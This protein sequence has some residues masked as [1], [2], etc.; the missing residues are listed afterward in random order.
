MVGPRRVGFGSVTAAGQILRRDVADDKLV[1]SATRDLERDFR[2]DYLDSVASR[3]AANVDYIGQLWALLAWY[4]DIRLVRARR[5]AGAGCV[6][7]LE[8]A[9]TTIQSAIDE[10][11]KQFDRFLVERGASAIDMAG[12]EALAHPWC[13]AEGTALDRPGGHISW[14]QSLSAAEIEISGRWLGQIAAT[15]RAAAG[16]G[17]AI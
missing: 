5:H 12:F 8:L 6:A 4:R 13:Q 3:A 10:R 15:A 9:L 14:V 16:R 7:A 1:G 11:I 2:R 17:L